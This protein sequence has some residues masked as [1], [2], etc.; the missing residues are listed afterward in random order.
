[1]ADLTTT[2]ATG[3]PGLDAVLNGGLTRRALTLIVGAPGAGKTVLA[4]HILFNAVRTG[5]KALVV[6]AYSE[7]NEQ[8]IEH[9]RSFGFF[10]PTL[11]GD[12]VQIF[13]L[14]SMDTQAD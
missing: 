12:A 5:M 9:M 2:F 11:V 1:M 14:T 6:T 13:T 10:D 8:Y 3:I 4:S 7:G